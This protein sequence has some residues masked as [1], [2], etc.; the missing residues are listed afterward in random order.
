MNPQ[1][2]FPREIS[3]APGTETTDRKVPL[4][5]D[6]PDVVGDPAGE[7]F[8]ANC[9]F[10]PLP[11]RAPSRCRYHRAAAGVH[12]SPLSRR[13]PLSSTMPRQPGSTSVVVSFCST[14]AGPANV[15]PGGIAAR[16]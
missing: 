16:R 11:E 5:P 2:G 12:R 10:T 9:I 6:G 4:D 13:L 15:R 8:D 14:I 7:R 3:G 1:L